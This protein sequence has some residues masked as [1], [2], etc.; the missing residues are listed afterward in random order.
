MG[1]QGH[2]GK[3]Q[4]ATVE[5]RGNSSNSAVIDSQRSHVLLLR[6]Q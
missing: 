2:L 1:L 6:R 5:L 4:V 3:P